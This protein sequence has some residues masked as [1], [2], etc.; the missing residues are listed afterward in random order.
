MQ[1]F[2]EAYQER[3]GNTPTFWGES[4]YV[5]AMVIDRTLTY[6]AETQGI[7]LEDLPDWV[8][9]NGEAF[10]A[11]SREIDLSDAPSSAITVDEYNRQVRDFYIVELVEEDGAIT[12]QLIET[13][14]EVTQFWTF[15]QQEFLSN[16]LF[17]RDYPKA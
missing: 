4:A 7:A 9:D 12:D 16:P 14:P 3:T 5:S 2:V 6:L 1:A 13:V 11:A 17:S 15:D 8:R 10:A